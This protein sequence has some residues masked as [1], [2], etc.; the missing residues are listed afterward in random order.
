MTPEDELK[1]V[2]RDEAVSEGHRKH[3][4]KQSG[5]VTSPIGRVAKKKNVKL[6][7]RPKH[8]RRMK[9]ARRK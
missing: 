9:R 2:R 1:A 6:F 3:E 7:M 8:T 4:N 5:N